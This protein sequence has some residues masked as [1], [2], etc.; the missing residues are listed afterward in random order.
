MPLCFH[1]DILPNVETWMLTGLAEEEL[2]NKGK[3]KG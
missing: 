2:G 1:F 3:K